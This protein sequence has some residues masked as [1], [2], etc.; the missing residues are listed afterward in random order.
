MW[1][2]WVSALDVE[3]ALRRHRQSRRPGVAGGLSFPIVIDSEWN[4]EFEGT[5]SGVTLDAEIAPL[6]SNSFSFSIDGKG[7][8]LTGLTN[9]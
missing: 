5:I 9:Q 4:F 2:G 6:G 8:D 7:L 3:A 1:W